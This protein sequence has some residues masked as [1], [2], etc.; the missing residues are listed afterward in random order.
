MKPVLMKFDAA[1]SYTIREELESN[2]TSKYYYHPQVEIVYFE[3]GYGTCIIGNKVLNFKSG[4]I[5]ILGKNLPH[6]FKNDIRYN[7]KKIE[8]RT[9]VLHF[10]EDYWGDIFLNLPDMNKIKNLL[11]KVKRGMQLKGKLKQMVAGYM[12]NLFVAKSSDRI[13]LLLQVLNLVSNSKDRTVILPLGFE[14]ALDEHNEDRINDVYSYTMKNY[15][16]KISTQEIASVACLSKNSFCRYFKIKTGKTYT[17]FLHEIRINH[18]CKLLTESNLNISQISNECGFINYANFFRY[19]KD[20]TGKTPAEYKQMN[21]ESI[22][23]DI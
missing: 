14:P 22:A 20:L 16:K 23:S 12:K 21:T 13:I 1:S 3:K 19:F 7:N 18:A 5:F 11:V 17:K 10:L 4:D 9:L 15:Y 8:I 2:Q 6:L